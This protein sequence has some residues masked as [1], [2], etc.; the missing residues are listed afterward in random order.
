MEPVGFAGDECVYFLYFFITP[1]ECKPRF[2]N[3]IIK[4]IIIVIQ[5]NYKLLADKKVYVSV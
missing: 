2:C 3:I 5:N 4:I 1:R